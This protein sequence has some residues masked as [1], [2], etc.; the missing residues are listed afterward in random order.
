MKSED[1]TVKTIRVKLSLAENVKR[2]VR[3]VSRYPYD[4]DWMK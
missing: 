4:M 3:I 2:F 1:E